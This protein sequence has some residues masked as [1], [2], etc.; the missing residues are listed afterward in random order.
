MTQGVRAQRFPHGCIAAPHH[1]ATAAGHDVLAAG[2]NAVDAAVA[3][4]LTLGVVAP[5]LCGYGGDLFAIVWDGAA[6]GLASAGTAPAR[7]TPAAVGAPIEAFGPHAVT[8]PGGVAGWFAL[9]DRWGTQSFGSLASTALRYA[10]D[11]FTVS[12]MAAGFLA[13]AAATYA[14]SGHE[15]WQRVYAGVSAGGSLRQPEL[16]RTIATLAEEGPDAY[17]KGAI[18]AAI[19]EGVQNW[20]GLLEADDLAAHSVADAPPL[21]TSFGEFDVLELPPPTQGVTALG[22]LRII[23]GIPTLPP[24]GSARTHLLV[25]AAKLAL[26]ERGRSVTDPRHM[27]VDPAALC[28]ETWAARQRAV[29]DPGRAGS[30]QPARPQPGGTAYLC[31]ADPDGLLV[32]LIQSNFMGFGSGITVPGWG[33]NLHNRGAYF[34]TDANHVDVIAARKQ[35]LHTLIPGLALR[36]GDPAL[37]FGTMGGDSQAVIHL[38]L[39]TRIVHDGDDVQQAIAAPRWTVSPADWSVTIEQSGGLEIIEG[40]RARGH[41]VAVGGDEELHQFGHA[42]AIAVT[43]AGYAAGTDPRT[44]GAAHGL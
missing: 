19:A 29:I 22:M 36:G 1:L 2:G 30:P 33:I 11:G 15:E 27:R 9:L 7:A 42:H 3:A 43:P 4:N 35:P 44:E 14:G 10:R 32:S 18:A 31:A 40:L 39:L 26:S 25:E 16:A 5:Y 13:R 8:V 37:V 6:N 12:A 38:Q 21:S 28:S 41:A 20:G 34:S 24:P 17:Y 23:D